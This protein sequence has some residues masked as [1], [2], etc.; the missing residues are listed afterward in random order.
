MSRSYLGDV[1]E[2]NLHRLLV[3]NGFALVGLDLEIF[4]KKTTSFLKNRSLIFYEL[5]KTKNRKGWDD[6]SCM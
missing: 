2:I 4:F 6:F 5:Q 1:S 3:S